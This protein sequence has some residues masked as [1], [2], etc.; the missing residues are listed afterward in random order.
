MRYNRLF[1]V[2]TFIVCSILVFAESPKREFRAVWL[3]AVGVDWPSSKSASSQKNE[4]CTILDNLD[5]GNLNAICYHTRPMADAFYK[6]S[7]EPWSHYLTGTRGKAPGYDPL[8]YAIEQAH[9]RGLEVH[10]WINP[11]RYRAQG[12]PASY[13]TNDNIT[14]NHADWIL[15]YTSSGSGTILDPGNPEVRAYVVKVVQ[16]IVEKYDIDGIVFDDYFYPYKGTTNEDAR[17]MQLYKPSSQSA[18]DWRRENVDKTV[19][20][21]YDMIQSI[22]PY[23]RF[24]ISPFGIYSTSK[25]AH[26]KYGVSKPSGIV[27]MDAYNEIYCSTLEWMQGGYVDYISPQLYW[28]T[29]SSGQSY[30]TLSK[31][32]S[33]MAQT[34]SNKLAGNKKVHFFSSQ[35]CKFTT[36]EMGLEID[37]N[38]KHNTQNAPGSIFFSYKS[39]QT[40]DMA[41]YLPKNKFTQM[42][43]PPAMDWKT[44]GSLAAPTNLT[45]SGTTLSWSHTN[46]ERFTV[47]AYTKGTDQA[48]ALASSANLVGIV[49]GNS[50]NLS[51]VTYLANKTLAVCAY[52]RYGNEHT[53]GLYNASTSTPTPNSITADYTSV[54]LSG[55]Q[56]ASTQ[57]YK[58][59][60]IT[61]TNLSSNI[62][63]ASPTN[64]VVSVSKLDGWNNLTGG[65]LRISLNTSK[66]ASTYNSAIVVSSGSA[67]VT[68]NV[69]A[70]IITAT[71]A[72]LSTSTKA[73]SLSGAKGQ[74]PRPYEVV[75]VVGQGL[76]SNINVNSSTGSVIVEKQADWD[77]KKGGTLHLILNTTGLSVGNYSGYVAVQSGTNRQE[78]NITATITEVVVTPKLIPSETTINLSAMKG[79]IAPYYDISV[80]GENLTSDITYSSSLEFISVDAGPNWDKRNGGRLR[81]TLSTIDEVGDYQA[82][83]RIGSGSTQVTL[84]VYA[85][86]TPVV[87]EGIS[88]SQHELFLEGMQDGEKPYQDVEIEGKGLLT[89][90]AVS[91]SSNI[92]TIEPQTGWDNRTG[93][94]LRIYLNTNSSV[95][96]HSGY[97]VFSARSATRRYSLSIEC[98][99][100]ILSETQSPILSVSTTHI[101]LDGKQNETPQPYTEV[102]VVGEALDADISYTSSQPNVIAVSPLSGWDNRHGGVLHITLNTNNPADTYNGT[103]TIQSGEKVETIQVDASIQTA[104][105]NPTPEA[106][107]DKIEM[108]QLWVVKTRNSSYLTEGNANRSMAYYQDKLYV[109]NHTTGYVYRF[110]TQDGSVSNSNDYLNTKN[111]SYLLFN[112]RITETGQMLFGNSK[113]TSTALYVYDVVPASGTATT[114]TQIASAALSGRSDY[115]Y[116]YGD[117]TDGG[118]LLALTNTGH[119]T[120]I[121]YRSGT[122]QTVSQAE[123]H[124]LPVGKSAKAIPAADGQSCYATVAGFVPTKHDIA[125]GELLESFEGTSPAEVDASGL[126]VFSLQEKTYMVTP[127]DPYGSIEVFE[128]TNGLA[129]AKKVVEATPNIGSVRNEAYTVDFCV[130]TDENVAYIY[131]LAP[132]NGL[133]AYKMT[134]TPQASFPT[135][136]DAPMSDSFAVYPTLDGV[137]V[138]FSGTQPVSIYTINGMQV[139]QAQ[140]TSSYTHELEQGVYLIR[141]GNEVKKY[142][143]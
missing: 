80:V 17:T 122:L 43:L 61:G 111:A 134:V 117:L 8:Q 115:F 23:V 22:K 142:V 52:D 81:I 55:L 24:G 143:Q 89:D 69:S 9:A 21:V 4:I 42:A 41:N 103:I 68:I 18:A 105:T 58:D 37:N 29:T 99:G 1:L 102:T 70:T 96:K 57:I 45:L 133:A 32:W 74:M 135:Q 92:F 110:N 25:A 118:F 124:Y 31:W 94:T 6:S 77:D 138:V 72:G 104:T 35:N 60:K 97:V 12:I 2:C 131:V 7:Y 109:A 136:V 3:A 13:Y 47:Y 140:A 59:I 73:V 28:E 46:A 132:N 71:T 62:S 88:L 27:G 106:S 101:S 36:S 98:T 84:T 130:T 56:G 10:A 63:V 11:F 66:A 116:P 137:K 125:T 26:D 76:T 119:L 64:D 19:R 15:D 129:H 20:A 54:T 65:T 123:G 49:Y 113:A 39:Y 127:A 14:K 141:V 120:Q 75:T 107:K 53:A 95:G 34:F 67:S 30:V 79:S 126:A 86:I 85:S 108:E 82:T 100:A 33:D 38:R 87:E 121:A 78:I 128:I 93:G 48:T 90:L 44:S 83:I 114:N 51:S 112:Y 139:A 16:E 40:L 91:S 50:I 5:A